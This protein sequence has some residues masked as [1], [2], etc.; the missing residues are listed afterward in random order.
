M[1][2]RQDIGCSAKKFANGVATGGAHV[3]TAAVVRERAGW[4]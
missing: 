4:R 2:L 3:S 1:T